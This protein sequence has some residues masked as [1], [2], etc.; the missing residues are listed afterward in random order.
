MAKSAFANL[1]AIVFDEADRI[2][3]NADMAGQVECD[4]C[5][6]LFFTRLQDDDADLTEV[7]LVHLA[8]GQGSF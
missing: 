6:A 5:P 3:V 8:L 2:A 4:F 1:Q 7:V